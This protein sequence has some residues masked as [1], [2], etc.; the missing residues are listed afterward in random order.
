MQIMI[1]FSESESY[2]QLYHQ[3]TAGD[4]KAITVTTR[5]RFC[6][7]LPQS[8]MKRHHCGFIS[9]LSRLQDAPHSGYEDLK[10]SSH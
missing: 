9:T 4:T 3:R 7:L 10:L 1:I 5:S 2:L 6:I 8:H